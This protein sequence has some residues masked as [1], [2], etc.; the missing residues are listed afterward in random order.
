M[1]YASLHPFTGW[2][3]AGAPLFAFVSAPWPRYWTVF[4]LLTNALASMDL[5]TR[6]EFDVQTAVL[7]R[8]RARLEEL[9]KQV[10]VLEQALA[11]QSAAPGD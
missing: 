11:R 7:A 1:I 3:D 6:E 2:R 4:D 10:A 5:V 8:T 9:E